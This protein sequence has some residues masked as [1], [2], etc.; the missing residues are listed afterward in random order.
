M[1]WKF[2][3]WSCWWTISCHFLM[4]AVLSMRRAFYLKLVSVE[5]CIVRITPIEIT[6]LLL[7][8]YTFY[9]PAASPGWL[10]G[11][12]SLFS[13][14]ISWYVSLVVPPWLTNFTHKISEESGLFPS[15]INHVLINEYQPNQGI[16]V[17]PE[18]GHLFAHIILFF[19]FRSEI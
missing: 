19:S 1:I 18:S 5:K 2:C 8:L 14:N 9:L 7:R 10:N 17:C 16:M 12:I 11:L 3:P 6:T 13:A 15:P 4:Q